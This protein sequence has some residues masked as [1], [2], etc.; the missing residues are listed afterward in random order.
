MLLWSGFQVLLRIR[1]G[2]RWG[3]KVKRPVILQVSPRMASLRQ[4]DMLI[5][6]FLPSTGGQGSEQRHFSLTVRG[7]VLR[8][9][10]LCVIIVTK[11]S[12]RNSSNTESE[13]T[14]PCNICV[15][16]PFPLNSF[17]STFCLFAWHL[18]SPRGSLTLT[19]TVPPP[20][21]AL[22]HSTCCSLSNPS[23]QSKISFF[24]HET[25]P[26]PSRW[27][28]L[29]FLCSH[30]STAFRDFCFV[31]KKYFNYS[32]LTHRIVIASQVA[33]WT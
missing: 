32:L 24:P 14:S 6:S 19:H 27:G 17:L 13:L 15:T 22:P 28:L 29:L 30:G 18:S 11:A 12:Q 9:R 8:G 31:L 2:G 1:N 26:G 5:S 16:L 4:G 21:H 20:W 33:E 10:S 3:S 23:F 25:S 7:R